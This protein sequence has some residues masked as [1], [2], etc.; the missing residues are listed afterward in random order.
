M[1]GQIDWIVESEFTGSAPAGWQIRSGSAAQWLQ[2]SANPAVMIVDVLQPQQIALLAAKAPHSI[3]VLT[4][5]DCQDEQLLPFLASF[6]LFYP[7][8][9]PETALR[10][11]TEIA[12]ALQRLALPADCQAQLLAC[13]HLPVLPPVVQQL[14]Q[15]LLDPD[16]RIERLVSVIEQDPVLS[17]RLLQL[18]NSAYMGFSHDTASLQMAISRLGLGLLYAVLLALGVGAALQH[19]ADTDQLQLVAQCRLIGSWLGLSLQELEQCVVL[20]LFYQL[21]DTLL[22]Q[23]NG[24]IKAVSPGQAGAFMLTLWGLP[25]L[26]SQSLLLQSEPIAVVA[27]RLALCLAL[28]RHRLSGAAPDPALAAVLA[29]FQLS[30]QWPAVAIP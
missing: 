19:S 3:R 23:A 25:A 14:Q 11:L 30:A 8:P 27:D 20:A 24:D 22:Q 1:P 5:P 2:Q 16:V 4:V 18:A 26:L 9:L 7:Q 29:R 13:T 12:D 21:G 6:H 10:Q 28:A 15:L 17:A